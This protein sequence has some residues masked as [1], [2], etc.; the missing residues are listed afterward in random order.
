M[1]SQWQPRSRVAV[2]LYLVNGAVLQGLI[3]APSD[4][5]VSDIIN[6]N[7]PFL[8]FIN[9]DG[10][11]LLIAKASLL[12]LVPDDENRFG[13]SQYPTADDDDQPTRGLPFGV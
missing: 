7:R 13:R 8:P 4:M 10:R 1:H 5:R 11:F 9:E 2:T 12:Q 6:S 3:F